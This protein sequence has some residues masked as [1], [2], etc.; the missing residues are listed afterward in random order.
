MEQKVLLKTGADQ[1]FNVKRDEE[2]ININIKG[3]S[4]NSEKVYKAS[5]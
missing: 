2:K 3:P 4:Q 1:P 5:V